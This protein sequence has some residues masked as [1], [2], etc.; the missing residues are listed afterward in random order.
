MIVKSFIPK[1]KVSILQLLFISSWFVPDKVQGHGMLTSPRSRNYYASVAGVT[2]GNT[3]GDVAA[4]YCPHCLNSKT[5]DQVCATGTTQTYD[6]WLDVNGNPMPWLAQGVY[7]EGQEIIIEATLTTNHAGHFDLYACPDGNASTQQ[8]FLDNPLTL[9]ED[10]LYGGPVDDHYPERAYVSP[11]TDFKFKYRLPMGVHGPQVMLQW[12]Y[13]TANSCFPPGYDR[14]EL[15][16]RGRGWLRAAGMSACDWPLNWTGDR[17]STNPEQFWNCA[18]ITVLPASPTVSP[19]PSMEPVPTI[20]Q[21][22][23][24]VPSPVQAPVTGPTPAGGGCCTWNGGQSCGPTWCNDSKSNCEG[25]CAGTYIG[26]PPSAPTPPAPTYPTYPP[27][28]PTAPVPPPVPAPTTPTVP[29]PPTVSQVATT[30]RY[31]DCSG[32][33]CGCAYL[34]FGPGTDSKPAHCYS[35]AMFAAPTGNP[36]GAKFYGTAAISQALGGGD[37]LSQGCGKCWKVRGWSN[38]PGKDSF[39]TTLVLKGTNYCPPGNPACS[40]NK[41]HFDIS[42]PGFDVTAYSLSNTCAEREPDEIDGFE[43]CGR[44]MIDSQD[45]D[46]NCDCSLFN[47]P[48]LKAGCENFYSLLWNNAQVD[49]EE[50]TCPNELSRLSCWDQNGGGY[51]PDIPQFCASN[52]DFTPTTPTAPTPTAPTPTTPAPTPTT[53]APT[54]PTTAAPS[55]PT[56]TCSDVSGTFMVGKNERDCAWAAARRTD[57]RCTRR[58]VAPNCPVTCGTCSEMPSSAPTTAPPFPA[59][60]SGP[61]PSPTTAP[62]PAPTLRGTS[63]PSLSPETTQSPTETQAPEYC[64]SSDLMNC[65]PDGDWCGQSESNCATCGAHWIVKNPSCNLMW[66]EDCKSD[67]DGCCPPSTCHDFGTWA[68]CRV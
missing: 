4:E 41:V 59:P 43:S 3:P 68:Q 7:T 28:T 16:L 55:S 6:N 19:A 53:P 47:D 42:A 18:D 26:N 60:T 9:V 44:W 64:C 34:P 39:Q 38:I 23:A 12:R 63:V 45:P 14:P 58:N 20:P 25:N 33:S 46:V 22:M 62:T 1:T 40:G 30:T 10:M 24:P 32:G 11:S 37:W 13:V 61:T 27:P 56:T 29:S 66:W 8:C 49:Y 5:V 67:P 15:D 36:Y 35:N 65:K 57:I 31:W 17:D 21:T 54:N 50:V 52:L 2:F 48:V 51:P